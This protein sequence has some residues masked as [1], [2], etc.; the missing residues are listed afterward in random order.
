MRPKNKSINLYINQII[1]YFSFCWIG[2]DK[3]EQRP[4]TDKYSI[5]PNG[6]FIQWSEW[7]LWS[8]FAFISKIWRI[9]RVFVS[10]FAKIWIHWLVA[11][12]TMHVRVRSA[13]TPATDWLMSMEQSSFFFLLFSLHS[14]IK[15]FRHCKI[16]LEIVSELTDRK[17]MIGNGWWLSLYRANVSVEMNNSNANN[18]SNYELNTCHQSDRIGFDSFNRM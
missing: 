12:P 15:H 8:G 7:A 5:R 16:N 13:G 11:R 14:A 4:R 9:T 17:W 1:W 10:V 18:C 6:K 2:R 3:S